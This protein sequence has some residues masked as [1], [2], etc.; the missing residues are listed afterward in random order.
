MFIKSNPTRGKTE[1]EKQADRDKFKPGDNVLPKLRRRDNRVDDEQDR[2]MLEEVQQLSLREVGIPSGNSSNLELPRE[3]RR[4][5]RSRERSRDSRRSRD[6]RS[7][8][9]RG[10]S[11]ARVVIPS[12]V[13]EHQSSLRSLLSASDLD[14]D[15][16]DEDLVRQ[17]LE[18]LV[19]DGIDLNQIGPTQEDEITERLAEA[20]RRRHVERQN[21]RQRERRERRDRLAREGLTSS[22]SSSLLPVRSPPGRLDDPPGRRPHSRS[23]SG[24]STPHNTTGPPISRPGLIEA[25]NRGGR[26]RDRHQRSS[27]QG[28]SRSARRADRPDS[29]TIP[30]NI[31]DVSDGERS[32]SSEN[33]PPPERRQSDNQHRSRLDARL[34]FRNSLR[35]GISSSPNT[36]RTQSFTIPTTESPTV[37]SPDTPTQPTSTPAIT[38]SQVPSLRRVTD[39]TRSG[40]P[41]NVN[42]S[43]PIVSPPTL[44]R[45]TTDPSTIESRSRQTSGSLT[46]AVRSFMEPHINCQHCH[47]EHIEYELHY[48]CSRCDNGAYNVCLRCYRIGKGCKHWFGFGWTAWLLYEKQAPEGGH[49]PGH[50]LPHILI[51]RRY[52][53]PSTPLSESSSPPHILMSE[54]DPQ[55]RLDSGVFCDICKAYSNACYWKCDYCNEGDW[56]FCN[57]CVNQGR[58]CTH[59]L[60]PLAQKVEDAAQ[61]AAVE[62][63][64]TAPSTPRLDGGLAPPDHDITSGTPPLT[65]RTASLIRGP[66]QFT[67]ADTV[68]RPLTFTTLCNVCRYPIPPSHTRFHCLKCNAGDYDICTNCYQKANL[69]NR[70]SREDGVN[71]WRK[72]LR[73]HRMVIVGFEDRNGGQRRIV[74]H[75]LVGGYAL[76]EEND[77]AR[78]GGTAPG[79]VPDEKYKRRYPPDGGV[80]LRLL[81]EWRYWPDEGVKDELSFP[82]GAEIREAADINGDWYWG[83]YCGAKGLFPANHIATL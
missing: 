63:P 52:R 12:R 16:V 68:F 82:R 51:G 78:P 39:P 25:A 83:M 35:T 5:E 74:V 71:G 77:P 8:A 48:N 26:E 3:R 72:C 33:R 30:L 22:S 18:E 7:S 45:S 53:R 27:S 13:V 10:A 76:K 81:A 32:R 62:L 24:T 37:A 65:P 57:D 20:V 15:D 23:E 54:D 9:S 29:L 73:G 49:P 67:I 46:P 41:L 61:S 31:Q 64:A 59:P 60:L 50:E 56:G 2:R 34:Q 44:P 55:E 6:E 36:P 17:V 70:I 28:S 80:G 40:Q 75:E 38:A 1:A 43:P 4:R 11:P 66:G 58:H 14:S 47:K 21:E 19:A 79:R 69:S 42:G